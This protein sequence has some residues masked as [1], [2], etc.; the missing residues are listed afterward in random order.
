MSNGLDFSAE[1]STRRVRLR[2][3]IE[4]HAEQAARATL[5]YAQ[6]PSMVNRQRLIKHLS[7]FET[8]SAFLEAIT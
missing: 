1:L 3:L 5:V 8:A 6:R 4:C 7:A 2:A